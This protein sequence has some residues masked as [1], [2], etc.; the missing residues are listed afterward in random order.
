MPLIQRE[1][2]EFR[3]HWNSHH[4]TASRG[5]CLGGIPDDLYEMPHHHGRRIQY[6]FAVPLIIT[7]EAFH[8]A[9][10]YQFVCLF[11]PLGVFSQQEPLTT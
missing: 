9:I 6:I 3:K 1:L 5:D 4:I 2:D 8:I 10:L 11:S 7:A